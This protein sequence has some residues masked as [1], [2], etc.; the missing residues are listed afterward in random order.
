MQNVMCWRTMTNTRCL[1]LQVLESKKS[2]S[3]RACERER[4]LKH[5]THTCLHVTQET[6]TEK[7]STKLQRQVR[8][9][10][11]QSYYRNLNLT[12]QY[13]ESCMIF[14]YT[15]TG[16]LF[17][18]FSTWPCPIH[19]LPGTGRI[20]CSLRF[21]FFLLSIQQETFITDPFQTLS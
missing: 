8:K 15:V 4:C 1:C 5:C 6:S 3:L 12:L 14:V 19:R 13:Y 7:S 20:H 2:G 21:C 18:C 17:A 11:N 9:Y 16:V 10:Q